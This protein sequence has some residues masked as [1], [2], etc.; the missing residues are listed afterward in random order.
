MPAFIEGRYLDVLAANAL[1]ATVSP[2]LV[3]GRNRLRDVFLDPD[4]R[5]LFID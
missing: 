2:P 4:E 5:D 3:T 1:A